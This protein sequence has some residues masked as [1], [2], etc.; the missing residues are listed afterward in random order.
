MPL[1]PISVVLTNSAGVEMSQLY[2]IT[3]I[4]ALDDLPEFELDSDTATTL[5]QLLEQHGSQYVIDSQNYPELM[6]AIIQSWEKMREQSLSCVPD[7]DSS[8]LRS[9]WLENPKVCN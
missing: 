6:H 1:A 3:N 2:K 4:A 9:E 7:A 8:L 5:T